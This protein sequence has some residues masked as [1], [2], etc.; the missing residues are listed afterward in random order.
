MFFMVEQAD[1]YAYG[2][3]ITRESMLQRQNLNQ[4]VYRRLFE[5]AAALKQIAVSLTFPHCIG[6][7]WIDMG[8]SKRDRSR[9]LAIAPP[10]SWLLGILIV[11]PLLLPLKSQAGS[12][13]KAFL[14]I[15]PL[16]IP[17]CG[18]GYRHVNNAYCSKE[19]IRRDHPPLA[20]L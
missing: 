9:L 17:T 2:I 6:S 10:L 14:T 4:L 12:F 7:N 11:Y 5:L 3:P 20:R 15:T 18:A 16:L 19:G 1:H 8:G 13:E